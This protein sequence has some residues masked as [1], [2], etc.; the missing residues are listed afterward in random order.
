MI[1][2][3]FSCVSQWHMQ[4]SHYYSEDHRQMTSYAAVITR[5]HNFQKVL[6]FVILDLT[7][8]VWSEVQDKFLAEK[9]VQLQCQ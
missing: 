5:F 2:M 6:P 4:M 8:V 9:E 1:V 7:N 3:I